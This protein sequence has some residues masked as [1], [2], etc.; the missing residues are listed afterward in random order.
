MLFKAVAIGPRVKANPLSDAQIQAELAAQIAAGNLPKPDAN[1]LYMVHF[2]PGQQIRA[3]GLSCR[4]F[5]AYH[6]STRQ[7]VYYG[8][9][10]DQGPGSGCDVGCGNAGSLG[11]LTA[12]ASHEVVEAVTDPQV[13]AV[14]NAARFPLAWYD[15]HKDAR[16]AEY[17]EIG[18]V[19]AEYIADLK[20]PS[21]RLWKVQKM[22]SNK[23]NGCIVER[24][25]APVAAS[26]A[27]PSS[28]SRS[29]APV[30]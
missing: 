23:A 6:S 8:V 17:A 12:T 5:C 30:R 14:R 10:P 21:G 2:P 7:N 11:N 20:A 27:R 3:G 24:S 25:D 16:G 28:S 22:W 18:D 26:A 15:A 29:A 19:C 1:T 4:D 9:M 13:G